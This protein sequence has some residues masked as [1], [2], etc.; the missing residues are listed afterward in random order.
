MDRAA[1]TPR[2]GLVGLLLIITVHLGIQ[3]CDVESAGRANPGVHIWKFLAGAFLGRTVALLKSTGSRKMQLWCGWQWLDTIS[4]LALG[5][6]LCVGGQT[7]LG[8]YPTGIRVG[9]QALTMFGTLF[10]L[11][12]T[13]CEHHGFLLRFFAF[14]AL[15][16]LGGASYAAYLLQLSVMNYMELRRGIDFTST[17]TA[18]PFWIFLTWL[19]GCLVHYFIEIPVAK[20]TR[21]WCRGK[22]PPPSILIKV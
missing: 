20:R 4:G 9:K 10:F 12:L 13:T 6:S 11:W 21:G 2:R 22:Q 7:H 15:S 17:Y 18:T 16:A 5:F 14:P 1:T 8:T 19:L 3:A